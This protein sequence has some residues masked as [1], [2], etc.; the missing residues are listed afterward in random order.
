[1]LRVLEPDKIEITSATTYL[2]DIS[3][4]DVSSILTGGNKN[5]I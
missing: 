4:T 5:G 2:V 3:V 1:V